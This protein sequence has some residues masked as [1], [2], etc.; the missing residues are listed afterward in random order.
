KDIRDYIH[1]MKDGEK[2]APMLK[3][4][5]AYVSESD[6]KE[7]GDFMI[8]D[9]KKN[10]ASPIC[11]DDYGKKMNENGIF[12]SLEGKYKMTLIDGKEIEVRTV[13]DLIKQYVNE[14]FS[15]E[16]VSEIT[17]APIEGIKAIARDIAANS[18]TTLFAMGMGPNQFFNNVLKDRTV[19]LLASLTK[20]IGR[21]GG[22]VG[23]FSGNYRSAYF[24]GLPAYVY[25]NPF[26]IQLDETKPA[27][28]KKYFHFESAHFF[29]NSDRMLKVGD[30]VLT[31]DTHMP[32]PTKSVMVSNG[33]SLLANNKGHYEAVVNSYPKVEFIGVFDWWWTGSCEYADIVFGVAAAIT[34]SSGKSS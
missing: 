7:W 14:N 3:Q 23:S 17:W 32:T 6:R 29:N 4:D 15:P 21:V 10:A 31:G 13:F 18:G 22:N 25:E 16:I 20:N 33:N 26:N 19:L 9:E 1:V 30:K 24:S 27:E 8:W 2:P 12:P 11:R 5:G 28:V 34:C